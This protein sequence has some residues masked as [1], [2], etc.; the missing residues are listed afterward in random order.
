MTCAVEEIFAITGLGNRLP[1]RLV[2]LPT[3]E[4]LPSRISL[5]SRFDCGVAAI[6]HDLKY[7]LMLRWDAVANEESPSNVVINGVRQLPFGP[8]VDK[9]K[10]SSGHRQIIIKIRREMRIS[11]VGVYCDDRRMSRSKVA[12]VVV[13]QDELLNL[14]LVYRDVIQNTPPDF[15]HNLINDLA[16]VLRRVQ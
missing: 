2:D 4:H 3:V 13:F 10:V 6:T 14:D 15:L 5:L 8:H 16:H 12:T 7:V 1:S 11:T 9:E